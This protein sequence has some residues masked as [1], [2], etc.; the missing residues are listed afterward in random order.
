M[1]FFKHIMTTA[2]AV[3][4]LSVG[5]LAGEQKN[6]QRPPKRPQEVEQPK[7]QQPPPPRNNENRG[8]QGRDRGDKD[9]RRGRP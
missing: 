7:K 5:A 6:D 8:N 9:N 1:R 3:G 2:L 4:V